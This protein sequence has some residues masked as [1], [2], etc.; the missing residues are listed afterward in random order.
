MTTVM[1]LVDSSEL[2]SHNKNKNTAEV[3]NKTALLVIEIQYAQFPV[4]NQETVL[5]NISNSSPLY[6][7][8]N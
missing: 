4:F 5:E 2:L 8:D 1:L 7:F 3:Q 6:T